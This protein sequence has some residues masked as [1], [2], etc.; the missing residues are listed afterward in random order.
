MEAGAVSLRTEEAGVSR[1][2]P[3]LPPGAGKAGRQGVSWKLRRGPLC[4]H[5]DFHPE[6]QVLDFWLDKN[7]SVSFKPLNGW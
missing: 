6:T 7:K 1:G 2:L 3:G 5:L 4:P